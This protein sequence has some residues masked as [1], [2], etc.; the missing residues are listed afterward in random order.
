MRR[1]PSP[2][3]RRYRLLPALA[4]AAVAPDGKTQEPAASVVVIG[5]RESL[6]AGLALK[7]QRDEVSDAIVADEIGKLPDFNLTEALQRIT[8]VQATR[9]RG[10]G[11]GLTVRG[12]TQVETTLNGREIFTAGTGRTL[13]FA[14]L[15]AEMIASATVFKSASA[16]QL[17]GGIGGLVDLRT[18][19]PFDFPGAATVLSARAIHGDLVQRGEAQ[20]SVLVSRRWP[21]GGGHQLGLLFNGSL[22]ERAFREDS[23]GTGAPQLRRDLLPD[24]AVTVPGSTS[25]TS[26]VGTRRRGA[27]TLI[28]QWRL[29][30]GL[31]LQAEAHL[32][33]FHTR[34]DSQQINVA[35]GTGVEPGSVQ[36][37]DGSSD[38][39]RITWLDAPV[40]V[41]SFARDTVDR[42]QQAAIGVRH[43]GP[44]LSWSADVSHTRSFN[45]LYFSGPGF[46]G[47]AA[48]FTHDL[49][50]SVPATR[51]SGT[52][53][54]DPNALRYT[55]LA[56]RTR[57]FEGTL[58]AARVDLAW[59]RPDAWWQ[60]F[61]AG[62]RSARR[63]AGNTPGLIFADAPLNGPAA[64]ATPARVQPNPYDD[65]MPGSTSIG[66][67]LTGRLDGARDAQ[68]LREAFGI[69]T[70]LPTSAAALSLW[71]IREHGDAGYV[72][73]RF[74]ADT[75]DGQLGLR[76]LHT[77]S[78]VSGSRTVQ[79]SGRIEPLQLEHRTT[80]LLPS[81]NLRWAWRP[82]LLL[83]LAA[84][85]TLTRPGFDQLSPSLSLLRNPI[86]PSLN[87]GMAGN[88]ELRPM[89]SKNLDLAIEHYAGPSSAL[90][91]TLFAKRV[92]GFPATHSAPETHDGETYQVSRPRNSDAARIDG[93]ELGGQHFFDRLPGAWRG[94]GVQANVTW[95]DSR[96]NDRLLGTGVPLQNLS[97]R[98]ANLIGLYEHGPWSARL[99]WNRRSSFVSGTT[100]VVG[101]GV[102]ANTTQGYGWL[103]ASIGLRLT[104]K[105][106][107]ALEGTNLLRT[108]RDAYFGV[109][110]RPQASLLNDRQL[111]ARVTL[112]L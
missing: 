105:V 25:E 108:R 20:G 19:R 46:G 18:R 102:L 15:P 81:L 8:G 22:Q 43:S 96:T 93:L 63:E 14:D 88:P 57:V 42:L 9:D 7:R 59:Q 100:S 110:T 6:S 17:E 90:H 39:R 16:E 21:L 69:T 33:E 58:D 5:K 83:R 74:S 56:Y 36:L 3:R 73:G 38:V 13:D 84:S 49:S 70:P 103:D 29:P 4:L 52:D 92:D 50:G 44:V 76:L 91:A 34:Q 68:A 54:L 72:M 28:A 40:S 97:R 109:P 112:Q 106:S 37:F 30:E 48:R 82:E 99:A 79:P 62:L 10:E 111:G 75:L 71:Q 86:T 55:L 89:R 98:S 66:R 80:D 64:A 2:R 26:S 85:R 87:Q 35:A 65:F 24:R 104:D 107:V 51:I 47:R 1:W 45:S 12:L 53:L 32:V 41:L 101:L 67:Y 31:E 11:F 78:S 61:S 77:R 94:L 23:K 95:I 27:G 60:R